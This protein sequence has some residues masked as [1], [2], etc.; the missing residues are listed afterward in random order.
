MEHEGADEG[1]GAAQAVLVQQV[2]HEVGQQEGAHR[3]AGDGDA[4]GQGTA[5]G[6]VMAHQHH[7]GGV[8]QG[9]A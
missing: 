1:E 4:V 7:A 8:G 3:A 9:R 5:A 2:L 6:E